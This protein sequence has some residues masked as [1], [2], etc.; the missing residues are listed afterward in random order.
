[1]SQQ[2]V[3]NRVKIARIEKGD[4]TQMELARRI[5]VT[6]QTISLIEAGKYNPTIK[7]CLQLSKVLGQPLDRLFWL[8]DTSEREW[9]VTR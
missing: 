8:E 5:G 4:L 2:G 1:M 7:L 6:R 3:K 9:G